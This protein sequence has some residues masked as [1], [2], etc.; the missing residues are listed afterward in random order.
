DPLEP[1]VVG[2]RLVGVDA[3]LGD[4]DGVEDEVDP[5]LLAELV[6]GQGERLVE[7]VDAHRLVELLADLLRRRGALPGLGP[8]GGRGGR[9][10]PGEEQPGKGEA[11]RGTWG[12]HA[13][14]SWGR[15]RGGA[16]GCLED[17]ARSPRPQ[18]R[19]SLRPEVLDDLAQR[20]GQVQGR[21]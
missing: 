6:D 17:T 12:R 7:D 18:S 3:D 20:G 13:S 15:G 5:R 14:A 4:G 16:A 8:R 10:G 9:R 2:R 1:G 11:P 21:A 19:G